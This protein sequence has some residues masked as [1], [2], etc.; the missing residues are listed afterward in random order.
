[1]NVKLCKVGGGGSYL[2]T[3][4]SLYKH[5]LKRGCKSNLIT[6]GRGGSDA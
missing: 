2:K 1:M 4:L 3:V 6:Y 5:S